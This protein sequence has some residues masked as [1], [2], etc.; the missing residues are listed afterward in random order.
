MQVL[1]SPSWS[2]RSLVL[3][4]PLAGGGI[5]V[6][7]G[8]D[9][10]RGSSVEIDGSFTPTLPEAQVGPEDAAP[11]AATMR[12]AHLAPALPPIDFCYQATGTGT[13]EGPVLGRGTNRTP[14]AG[15]SDAS[16]AASDADAAPDATADDAATSPALAYREVSR[17]LVIETAGPVTIAVVPG[18]SATCAKPLFVADVTLDPGKLVTIAALPDDD[19]EA[20][21]SGLRFGAFV[22]DRTAIADKARVRIVHA[23][24][25]APTISVRAVASK[26]VT[27]AER[28]A[29]R[30]VPTS[31]A[32]A[33]VDSLGYATLDPLPSPASLAVVP[34]E[35]SDA[36]AGVAGW[37]SDPTNLGL[38][39]SSLHTGFVLTGVNRPFEVVWCADTITEGDRTACTLVR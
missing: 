21:A 23:A 24:V 28:V 7:C 19:A 29:P 17:Y 14:D 39:G 15:A 16:D 13:F 11:V 1:A 22:D 8:D 34:A 37:Q 12:L 20:G 4:A 2:F 32:G 25:N 30:Q 31:T 36:E 18:G 5:V 10:G 33:N 6:A 26:T 38:A 35:S 27:I 9:E 3:L